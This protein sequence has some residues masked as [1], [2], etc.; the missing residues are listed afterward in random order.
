MLSIIFSKFNGFFAIKKNMSLFLRILT[1]LGS[2][3]MFL[4]GM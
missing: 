4:Y 3:G 1:L 2:L